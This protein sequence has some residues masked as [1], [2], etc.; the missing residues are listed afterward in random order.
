MQPQGRVC[1][2]PVTH[3]VIVRRD[4]PLGMLAAQVVHAA[5]ESSPGSL[6]EHT[7]AV[8]LAA[9]SSVQLADLSIDLTA[10]GIAHRCIYES[11]EPYCGQLLAVGVAPDLRSKLKGH[12]RRYQLLR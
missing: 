11:D 5:G 3:Y 1:E 9:K 6:P 10:A 2:D 8:V 7:Y 12:F 4:L